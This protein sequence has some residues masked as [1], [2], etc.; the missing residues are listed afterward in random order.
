V[1]DDGEVVTVGRVSS[2]WRYP[3]KSMQGEQVDAADVTGSG[4]VGDRAYAVVDVETGKVASAKHPRKWSALLSFGATFVGEAPLVELT[5]PDGSV[6]RSDDHDID[7]A[8]SDALGRAVTLQSRAPEQRV[9]EEVWPDIDGLAPAQF[10]EQTRIDDD[11]DGIVSD[12]PMGLTS[13]PGTFFD[14]AV[15]HVMTSAT[16]DRLAALEPDCE[17]DVRRYRP[18]IVVDVADTGF[19][20]N[21]WAGN[22]VY[23]GADVEATAS[24]PT[25][26]CVMT[27]L[28]QPALPR[29][30]RTLQAIARH[31]RIEIAGLGTWACAGIYADVRRGGP[32]ARGDA[33]RVVAPS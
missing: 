11:P 10:I 25:M 3:V 20:E 28:A 33:V 18:N 1:S 19:V 15:L 7:A 32:I 9:L 14:L 12:I 2:L 26:R 31:N 24:I 27:T 16:L 29:D 5:F 4:I 21:D 30:L 22:V 8:L 17:F 6:H 23:V 13:P